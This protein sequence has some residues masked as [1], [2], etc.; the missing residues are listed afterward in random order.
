MTNAWRKKI[1]KWNPPISK[2]ISFYIKV[3]KPVL[4]RS[5]KA[6]KYLQR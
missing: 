6:I 5:K 4:E 1:N 3:P 2:Q